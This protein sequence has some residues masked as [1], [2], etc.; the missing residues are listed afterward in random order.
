MPG[1]I[2]LEI[3]FLGSQ[4]ISQRGAIHG[5]IVI[6]R[7][8]ADDRDLGNDIHALFFDQAHILGAFFGVGDV[9]AVAGQ[10]ILAVIDVVIHNALRDLDVIDDHSDIAAAAAAQSQCRHQCDA[11]QHGAKDLLH[12]L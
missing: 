2:S 8:R 4:G 7:Q 11:C 5:D 12:M 9:D 1:F 6:G 10:V 3:A